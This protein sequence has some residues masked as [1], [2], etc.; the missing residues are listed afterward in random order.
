M[1]SAV[2]VFGLLS[3]ALALVPLP[4]SIRP[5]SAYTSVVRIQPPV[6]SSFAIWA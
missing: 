5:P 1:L 3:V 6:L 4:T 2:M